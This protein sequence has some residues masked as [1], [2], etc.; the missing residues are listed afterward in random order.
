MDGDV[1][2]NKSVN[3]RLNLNMKYNTQKEF[4]EVFQVKPD[5]PL[6]PKEENNVKSSKN[7]KKIYAMYQGEN[8]LGAPHGVGKLFYDIPNLE[9]KE[10][11]EG[12]RRAFRGELV[13][14]R[15]KNGYLEY[16]DKSYYVGDFNPRNN[17]YHGMGRLS[18]TEKIYYQ[19]HWLDGKKYG[20][21][22]EHMVRGSVYVGNFHADMKHGQGKITYSSALGKR[23]KVSYQGEWKNDRPHGR[24]REIFLL[25][26]PQVGAQQVTRV[27][28]G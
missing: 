10:T 23:G 27:F 25:P 14:G 1:T 6:K 2:D 12:I 3:Y 28:D 21:G 19:G 13:D 22:E 18:F 8:K 5:A 15:L 11:I 4:F 17:K 20:Y 9:E 16:L 7:D 24:G 26:P